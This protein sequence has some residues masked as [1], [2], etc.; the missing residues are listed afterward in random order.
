VDVHAIFVVVVG[1]GRDIPH[2]SLCIQ[3][4]HG[5]ERKITLR[6]IPSQSVG[7]FQFTLS[8]A[9]IAGTTVYSQLKF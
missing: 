5:I 7:C 9:L 4:Y 2:V 8:I 6:A 3:S 1:I